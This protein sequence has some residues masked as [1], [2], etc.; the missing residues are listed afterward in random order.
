[1]D[2]ALPDG[3]IWS[4]T[5]DGLAKATPMGQYP[6][7]GRYG[8]GVINLRLPKESTEVVS[9]VI[10]ELKT[11]ILVLTSTGSVRRVR[12][13]AGAVGSRPVKPKP[14]VRVGGRS[15]VTG[16][17][18]LRM[19]WEVAPQEPE[20]EQLSLIQDEKPKATRSKRK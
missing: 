7:Q 19:R 11:E 4:I 13:D 1:M 14:V 17:R 9:I 2:I 3:Y 18:R 15:R 6:V 20:P 5:D 8:L 10:G 12:L 16:A